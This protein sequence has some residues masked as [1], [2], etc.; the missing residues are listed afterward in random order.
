MTSTPF[1]SGIWKS[2][3]TRSALRQRLALRTLKKVAAGRPL[4]PP[5][6]G[7]STWP[8]RAIGLTCRHLLQRRL[9]VLVPAESGVDHGAMGVDDDDIRRARDLVR[10]DAR[11]RIIIERTI[12]RLFGLEILPG[13]GRCLIH[14]DVDA[15]ELDPRPIP[16]GRGLYRRQ[17]S[18]AVRAPRRP[19]LE[20]HRPLSD[21]LT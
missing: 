10:L 1:I 2:V 16:S 12:G 3:R 13:S 18:R 7:D 20:K 14:G 17:Q 15:Q 4:R 9:K 19:E 8:P 6:A 5:G 21:P 11:P